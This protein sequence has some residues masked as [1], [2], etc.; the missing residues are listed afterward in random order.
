MVVNKDSFINFKRLRGNYEVIAN[1]CAASTRH[2]DRHLATCT[3]L[4]ARAN[5]HLVMQL[6]HVV[7]LFC[8]T[9]ITFLFYEIRFHASTVS[10]NSTQTSKS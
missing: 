10:S 9:S 3:L 1:N 7:R 6:D 2:F 4:S 8:S 5:I